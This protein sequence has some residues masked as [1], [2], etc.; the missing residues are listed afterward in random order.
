MEFLNEIWVWI[1]SAVGGLSLS[2]IISAITYGCLKGAFNKTISKINVESIADKATEKGVERVKKVSFTHN[3]Q[4]LV[5]SELKKINE[6]SVE[7]LKKELADVQAKYDNV[8]NILDKLACYFDNSIGVAEEKKDDLKQA[9]EKA[10]NKPMVAESIVADEI[11]EPTPKQ[12][13]EPKT[14]RKSTTKVER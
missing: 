13:V 14:E 10:Q 6:H 8:I 5:E 1:M 4:P 7:V 2:A 3:I 11:V 9:I 12:A